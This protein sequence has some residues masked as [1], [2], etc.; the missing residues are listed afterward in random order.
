MKQKTYANLL[1]FSLFGIT[2]WFFGNLYEGI[3]MTPNL[4]T[5]PIRKI[6]DWQEFFTATNPVFFYIPVAPIAIIITFYLFFKTRKE[7]PILKKHVTYGT[8]FVIL[9]LALG[10]FIITRINL[11]LF[12]WDIEKFSAGIYKLAVLWNILNIVRV[13]LLA[14]T[15]YHVFNAY[16]FVRRRVDQPG[17]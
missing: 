9:A 6:H 5:D 8:I 3:V 14:F 17:K 2:M 15:I 4:L 1:L 11:K 12:F 7:D 16:L 13:I 10:I